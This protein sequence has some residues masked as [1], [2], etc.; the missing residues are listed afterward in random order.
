MF[1]NS[2][3]T[4]L[5]KLFNANGVR[6]LV[7]GGYAVVQYTEPRFTKDLDL[8]VSTDPKNARFVFTALREFGA[9]LAGMTESDYFQIRFDCGKTRSGSFAR[10]ERCQVP[11]QAIKTI[12]QKTNARRETKRFAT[13]NQPGFL[14]VV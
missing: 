5:L 11:F 13:V 14:S 12:P 10:F 9:P 2:D 8:W 1:V 6:Y 4:E 3:Y 7:I